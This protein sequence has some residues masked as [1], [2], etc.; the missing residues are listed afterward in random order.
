MVKVEIINGPIGFFR[1]ND[2]RTKDGAEIIFNG[3]VRATEH[4]KIITA[5]EYEQYEDMAYSELKKIAEK[6][7][8]KFIIHDLFCKHR[9]GKVSVG[10][11]SLHVVIRSKHREEGF[12]AMN[13]FISELKECVPIWKWAILEDGTKIPSD[14]VS[15]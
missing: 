13:Y 9:I 4:D 11:S 2:S 1:L 12:I 6:T 10:Q 5:I 15:S 14:F 7:V 3:R 8:K